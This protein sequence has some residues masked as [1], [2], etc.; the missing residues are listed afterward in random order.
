MDPIPVSCEIDEGDF[1]GEWLYIYYNYGR[2]YLTRALEL[3]KE[4]R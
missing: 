4:E 2:E 3:Y 1:V